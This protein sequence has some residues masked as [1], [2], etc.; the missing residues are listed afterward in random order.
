MLVLSVRSRSR[1]FSGNG[2]GT[3]AA[4]SNQTSLSQNGMKFLGRV[5][6]VLVSGEPSVPHSWNPS[7]W[8]LTIHRISLGCIRFAILVSWRVIYSRRSLRGFAIMRQKQWSTFERNVMCYCLL[9]SNRWRERLCVE[10]CLSRRVALATAVIILSLYC[11]LV[12]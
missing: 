10:F 7:F 11:S 12:L 1:V 9:C 5:G 8:E 6:R 3:M 4:T 2:I